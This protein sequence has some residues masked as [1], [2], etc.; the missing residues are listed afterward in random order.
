MQLL[1][2]GLRR[3]LL[4]KPTDYKRIITQIGAKQMGQA[5]LVRCDSDF[6]L[7]FTMGGREY[8]VPAKQLMNYIFGDMCQLLIED[9][10]LGYWIL[11]DSFIRQYCQIHDFAGRRVGFAPVKQ[12]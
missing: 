5:A 11:G 9:G 1:T 8:H 10:D 7:H 3:S 2:L 4:Q 6:V 12:K